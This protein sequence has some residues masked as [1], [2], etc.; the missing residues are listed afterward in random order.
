[1][2]TV[3]LN[4]FHELVDRIL[5]I[6]KK[7][8][9]PEIWYRGQR[10][11]DWSL[12]PGAFRQDRAQIS[13]RE[14]LL[15]FKMYA[16]AVIPDCPS[17]RDYKKWLPIMQ[18]HGV[19]TRLLDWSLSPLV[20]LFFAVGGNSV[21]EDE[22]PK[23][24]AALFMF[25][26]YKWNLKHYSNGH[27]IPIESINDKERLALIDNAFNS[28]EENKPP[29]AVF[30]TAR[31]QRSFMQ[32]SAFTLHNKPGAMELYDE[33]SDLITKF[34]IPKDKIKEFQKALQAF[35]INEFSI[36]YD[37]DSLGKWVTHLKS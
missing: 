9:Y 3:D 32:Q 2:E 24:D 13:E 30:S 8:S 10:N 36:Y 37:P 17:E 15:R 33:K 31:F 11:A 18:H 16:P 21:Q 5:K 22:V 35:R 29:L 19:P 26:P 4:D 23:T 25:D 12:V 34:K 7:I 14:P 28:R 1:M 20:A 6:P 27:V